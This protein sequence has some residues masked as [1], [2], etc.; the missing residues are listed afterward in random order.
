MWS[1]GFLLVLMYV[2]MGHVMWGWPLPAI[3]A[4]N[5]LAI[6]LIELVLTAIVM[7]INQKF[8]ISGFK[9]LMK[10]APNMG[11]LVALG[12]AASFGYSLALLFGMTH[13]AIHAPDTVHHYL[14][15][16]YFESAAM[17]LT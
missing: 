4:E 8:F 7:V 10:G 12:S 6:A 9:S 15:E 11:T 3:L 5:V 17:I 14:H 16:F 1:L 13:A 2:S